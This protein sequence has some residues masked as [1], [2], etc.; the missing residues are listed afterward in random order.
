MLLPV[1]SFLGVVP[2]EIHRKPRL[3]CTDIQYFLQAGPTPEI[4]TPDPQIRSLGVAAAIRD[5]VSKGYV[6][7]TDAEVEVAVPGF[8]E[9]RK[10][11]F[12][13]MDPVSG[14]NIGVEVKTTLYD[15]IHLDSSQVAKDAVIIRSGGY[16]RVDGIPIRGVGYATYCWGCELVPNVRSIRLHEIL[17]AARI[18]FSHGGKPGET[19]P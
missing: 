17:K 19:L 10:Y 4:R 6:L 12:I 1:G 7:V 16:T 15:A 3:Q 8:A 9:P 18:P 14:Y 5:Y 2:F 11:D 13:V